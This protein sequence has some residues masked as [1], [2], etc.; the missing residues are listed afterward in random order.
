MHSGSHNYP[1]EEAAGKIFPRLLSKETSLANSSCRV[2]YYGGAS[3]AVPFTWESQPGTPKHTLS[4]QASLPPLTPPPSY[5]SKSFSN[6]LKNSS[7]P[8]LLCAL[9]P[10]LSPR[11]A[12]VSPSSS[13]SSVSSSSSSSWSS[14]TYSSSPKYHR[15]PTSTLSFGAR[16]EGWNQFRGCYPMGNMKNTF[17]SIVGHGSGQGKSN[18][19]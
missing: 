6:S 4:D 7:K 9:F 10:K 19:N 16:R 1:K 12:L 18:Y 3:G 14:S 2:L 5:Y 8:N 17:L 15:S 11:K 13:L